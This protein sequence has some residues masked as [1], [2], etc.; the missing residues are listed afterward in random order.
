MKRL[1]NK[2]QDGYGATFFKILDW[3]LDLVRNYTIP[4]AEDGTW[5]RPRASITPVTMVFALGLL[6]PLITPEIAAH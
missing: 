6:W 4:P 5:D 2:P 3:P 1:L